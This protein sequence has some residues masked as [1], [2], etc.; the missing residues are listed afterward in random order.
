MHAITLCLLAL[1]PV[2]DDGGGGFS[3]TGT[4]GTST[5]SGFADDNR[6]TSSAGATATYSLSMPNGHY[7][8]CLTWLDS[9]VWSAN[10][11]IVVKDGTTTVHSGTIAQNVFPGDVVALGHFFRIVAEVE[12]TSGTGVVVLTASGSGF[13]A[14]DAVWWE[15]IEEA[16][17][18]DGSAT[19]VL[20]RVEVSSSLIAGGVWTLFGLALFVIFL[21]A[22]SRR[23]VL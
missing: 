14:A 20:E 9:D 17:S 11:G 18:V 12:I 5:D 19:E 7:R 10:T 1:G 6:W 23:N 21:M 8:V 2:I 22:L 15:P 3:T 13:A 16:A 4:W